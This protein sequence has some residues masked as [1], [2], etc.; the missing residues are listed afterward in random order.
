MAE[1]DRTA[2]LMS[3]AR[4]AQLKPKPATT[5]AAWLTQM[6]ADAGHL[7]VNRILELGEVLKE[8]AASTELPA[9]ASGLE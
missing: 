2:S 9:V 5:P 1:T 6:A 7:H 4:L 8:Q 3:P